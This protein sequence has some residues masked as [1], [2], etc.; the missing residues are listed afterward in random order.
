MT[1]HI[2]LCA[3][4]VDSRVPEDRFIHR[5]S[6]SLL[7]TPLYFSRSEYS[8]I[9]PQARVKSERVKAWFRASRTAHKDAGRPDRIK[10]GPVD[11]FNRDLGSE[12]NTLRKREDDM[13]PLICV[14]CGED[15][16]LPCWTCVTCSEYEYTLIFFYT[17][18]HFIDQ[19][20]RRNI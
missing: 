14:V 11:G 12:S 6:H 4:C 17:I 8:I 15:V 13:A 9:L 1:D 19:Y 7:K 2:D 16:K 20:L 18:A 3:D 5:A 10:Q